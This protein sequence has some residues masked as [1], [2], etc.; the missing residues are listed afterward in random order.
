MTDLQFSKYTGSDESIAPVYDT[1]NIRL[2]NNSLN[3]STLLQTMPCINGYEYDAPLDTSI[4]TEVGSHLH[5]FLLIYKEYAFE[6][7]YR[8]NHSFGQDY[9]KQGYI[10][11][12][13]LKYFQT[14]NLI[15]ARGIQLQNDRYVL[16]F[17]FFSE[18]LVLIF[19]LSTYP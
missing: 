15:S 10:Y 7:I 11:C 6:F 13:L 8:N 3:S 12:K 1:C 19:S 16:I 4:I 2:Y 17:Q 14:Q 18:R 5:T 9:G